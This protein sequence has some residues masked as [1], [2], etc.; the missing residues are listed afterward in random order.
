MAFG[1]NRRL[2]CFRVELIAVFGLELDGHR[3]AA[4]NADVEEVI[5]VARGG[6]D[7][8]VSWLDER[9][10]GKEQTRVGA[11]GDEDVALGIDIEPAF[12]G[13]ASWRSLL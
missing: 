9:Q 5:G 1:C 6:D 3:H 11:R 12:D 10:D 4:G 2:E 8:L 13:G 7:D